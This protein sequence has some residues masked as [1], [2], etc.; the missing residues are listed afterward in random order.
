MAFCVLTTDSGRSPV[1]RDAVL[2]ALVCIRSDAGAQT[3][4]VAPS[5]AVAGVC[6]AVFIKPGHIHLGVCQRL[7]TPV[8]TEQ[9]SRSRHQ[10]SA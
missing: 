6:Q 2:A 7:V 1:Y 10:V 8:S 9:Y 4:A 3:L 5:I